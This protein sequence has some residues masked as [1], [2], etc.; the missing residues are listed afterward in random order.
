MIPDSIYARVDAI[1]PGAPEAK[2]QSERP[3][4]DTS[5]FMGALA[6]L[7]RVAWP[8]PAHLVAVHLA[9]VLGELERA[10][11]A[12][13]GPRLDAALTKVLRLMRGAS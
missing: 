7:Q 12:G 9:G 5:R 1:L 6:D 4:F 11:A 2:P 13:D 8:N 3:T 10:E